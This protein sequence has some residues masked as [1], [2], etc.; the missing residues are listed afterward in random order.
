MTWCFLFDLFHCVLL[1]FNYVLCCAFLFLMFS[2]HC[3]V[4]FAVRRVAKCN[5]MSVM[6]DVMWWSRVTLAEV[7]GDRWQNLSMWPL[8]FS[9]WMMVRCS[10]PNC[11]VLWKTKQRGKDR[12]NQMM[13]RKKRKNTYSHATRSKD[14]TRSKGAS[15]LGTRSY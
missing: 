14:A 6:Y 7:P 13:A 3:F 9:I 10:V 11:D 12:S 4:W 1:S 2:V 8:R 5:A 15:L